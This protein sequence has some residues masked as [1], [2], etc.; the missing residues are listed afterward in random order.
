MTIETFASVF[1]DLVTVVLA[2]WLGMLLSQPRGAA[3]PKVPEAVTPVPAPGVYKV[4]LC[5]LHHR[6][7]E[8][9]AEGFREALD[10]AV[11][12]NLPVG[13]HHYM[14]S[15]QSPSGQVWFYQGFVDIEDP[16]IN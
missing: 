5:I 11:R 16:T 10:L 6:P 9:Q 4:H 7:I 3:S 13:T 1:G 15:T 14:A 8:V 12:R 2:V